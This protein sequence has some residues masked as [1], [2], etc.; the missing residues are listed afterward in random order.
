L[1]SAGAED[2]PQRSPERLR[3]LIG[4]KAISIWQLLI[5]TR[6]FFS[7]P[8]MPT[9]II[10]GA[11]SLA[12]NKDDAPLAIADFS[13]AIRLNPN[14][15]AAYFS[16]ARA[17]FYS[18]NSA[19]A[20]ADVGRAAQMSPKDAYMA[21]WLD[22]IAQRSNVPSRLAESISNIDMTVWPAP[23]VQLFVGRTTLTAVPAA[24]EDDDP[25]KK[26]AK[27]CEAN[28]Y[29]GELALRQKSSMDE[30]VRQLR[31]AATAC[32]P[33]FT[34]SFAAKAELKALGITP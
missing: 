8:T 6:P 24:A 15:L 18:G 23:V 11:T 27:V 22:V 4:Q 16:R 3:T 9:H 28:F 34:E 2:K 17:Y 19:N 1:E 21:L 5:T 25:D 20:L 13:A 29:S 26:S 31:S 10:T 32:P 7:I 33:N 12:T 14:Y 30:A